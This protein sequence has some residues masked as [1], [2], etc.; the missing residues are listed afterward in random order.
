MAEVVIVGA[1]FGGLAA[2]R[3]LRRAP[4][5]VTIVDR[6]N[7]HLFQPLLYQVATGALNASD[8]AMA[9]RVILRG[10]RNARV[11]LGDVQAVDTASRCVQL[12]DG[13]LRYDYLVLATG[14]THSYFGR[15][16]W[17]EWAPGLKTVEDA[18]EIRRRIFLA[19]E[20]AERE[21]DPEARHAWMTFVIVGGGPTG[22]ELAG[23]LA[24]IARHTL[25]RDFRA[26]DP[27][28][29]RIVLVEGAGRVLPPY[30]ETLSEKARRQLVRLGVEILTAARVTGIDADGVDIGATRIRAR[31]VIWAAGVKASPLGRSLGVP[32]DPAGRVRVTPA[33]TIPGHDDVFVIGDL[34]AFAQDGRFVP[35]V[36][37]AAIQEGRHA[38]ANIERA[39]R[40]RSLVPFRY[41]DKGSFAVIGRGAAVGWIKR[42]RLS[43][44]IAWLAWL[45]VHIVYLIGFRNRVAVLFGWSYSY[46]TYQR[47]A[48]L[49]T[50]ESLPPLPRVGEGACREERR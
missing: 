8:I 18:L 17:A 26:I 16:D 31:T 47:A 43:G 3:A 14:A 5:D 32:V 44:A 36:S 33:L 40:G 37:P 7:H 46:L 28:A 30:D 11:L 42:V 6:R 34:A 13:T 1:G 19:Y 12:R 29:S 38:A 50:G 23:A 41:V 2:A 21:S 27:R 45:F 10:Q 22:V 48:R 4:V 20:A 25:E 35:G 9:V 15:D 49:I 24:E 39:V